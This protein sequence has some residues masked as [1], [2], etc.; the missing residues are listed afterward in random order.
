MAE[1]NF[2]HLHVQTYLFYLSILPWL[3]VKLLMHVFQSIKIHP[4]HLSRRCLREYYRLYLRT[5]ARI[6]PD[7]RTARKRKKPA[8]V[9]FLGFLSSIVITVGCCVFGTYL[10]CCSIPLCTLRADHTS[11]A[12]RSTATVERFD[13]DSFKVGIDNHASRCMANCTTHF[14]DLKL[15][16][17][18][19]KVGGIND[20]LAI[21]GVGTFIFDIEDDDGCLHTIKVPNSLYLP[22]L[23]LCLLSPQHWAQEAK[24][25]YPRPRGTRMENDAHGCVLICGKVRQ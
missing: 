2:S 15:V 3:I 4:N 21:K 11:V 10:R 7:H 22:E 9:G 1:A 6:T 16:E 25:D 14:E 17:S 23:K 13:T 19:N 12:M 5:T 18:N 24:D 8:A 20:G